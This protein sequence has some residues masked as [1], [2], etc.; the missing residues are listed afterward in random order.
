MGAHTQQTCF[1][2]Q[3]PKNGSPDRTIALSITT[4]APMPEALQLLIQKYYPPINDDFPQFPELQDLL[5][6][7]LE[8]QIFGNIEKDGP[9]S[10]FEKLT[11]WLRKQW[12]ILFKRKLPLELGLMLL[13][14][15]FPIVY[16]LLDYLSD[17]KTTSSPCSHFEAEIRSMLQKTFQ[18]RKFPTNYSPINLWLTN[19]V[20]TAIV[21]NIKQKPIT[22][23][24]DARLADLKT[25]GDYG[26]LRC[27]SLLTTVFIAFMGR[28]SSA[29]HLINLYQQY[30]SLF[31][32]ELQNTF[33][34]PVEH[35]VF[36]IRFAYFKKIMRITSQQLN[37]V[38]RPEFQHLILHDNDTQEISQYF[39]KHLAPL[40]LAFRQMIKM[41]YAEK[42]PGEHFIPV[43]IYKN[44]LETAAK[45]FNLSK[46]ISQSYPHPEEFEALFSKEIT[47][48]LET[49]PRNIQKILH[50]AIADLPSILT[51]E[52]L[53]RNSLSN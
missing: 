53:P 8:N 9:K 31:P 2:L 17:P 7:K 52:E 35:E 16:Q 49:F 39:K 11:L 4:W 28:A 14:A 47:I 45:C 40:A 33:K 19:I 30:E 23:L 50:K 41:L 13:A 48:I 5:T 42:T 20:V 10:I 44:F 18:G 25:L 22:S 29:D 24:D 32:L 26:S 21:E 27:L 3:I 36:R 1:W 37:L 43:H 12:D 15:H 51:R 6:K 34:A 46:D 38:F